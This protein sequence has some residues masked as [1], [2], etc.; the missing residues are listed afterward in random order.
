MR[1]F[2]LTGQTGAGKTTAA[3]LFR[4]HGWYVIDTD[5]LA[6]AIVTPPSPVLSALADAFGRDLILPDGTLD[7]KALVRRVNERENGVAR[8]NALTHPAID[9]LVEKEIATAEKAGYEKVLIDAAALLESP[10]KRRCSVI[11]AITANEETRLSRIMARDGISRENALQRMRMQHG[12]AYYRAGADAVI[13]NND[14][15]DPETLWA[16]LEEY[17]EP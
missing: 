6:R 15:T 8:L 3:N 16:A 2:G 7:R 4:A 13:E 10:T 17:D 1:I 12:E 5:L 9:D 14:P 11:L